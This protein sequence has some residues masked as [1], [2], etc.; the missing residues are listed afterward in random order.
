MA[1]R[2][3]CKDLRPTHGKGL[4]THT[5][6]QERALRPSGRPGAGLHQPRTA[7]AAAGAGLAGSVLADHF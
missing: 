3:I 2:G 1:E 5:V 7:A 4:H 6:Q